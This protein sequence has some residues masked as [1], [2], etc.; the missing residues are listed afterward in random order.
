MRSFLL[1]VAVF[2][3]SCFVGENAQAQGQLRGGFGYGPSLGGS[4]SQYM[5]P[6]YPYFGNGRP[7][8]YVGNWNGSSGRR[9]NN[10]VMQPR[11]VKPAGDGLPIKIVNP[12]DASGSIRYSLNDFD[13]VIE[14]GQSQTIVNDRPWT[15]TFDRGDKFG[16]A[17]YSLSAGTYTFAT[18]DKGRQ[19]YHDADASKLK[20]PMPPP[21]Q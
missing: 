5:V 17:H 20:P 3:A 16:T 15:I 13:Y 12:S 19:V 21:P 8:N 14:P 1:A 9:S 10:V 2:T 11:V 6:G 7:S 18:T 4:N